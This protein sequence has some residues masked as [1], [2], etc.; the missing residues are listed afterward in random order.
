MKTSLTL[1]MP[2]YNEADS[3]PHV[4]PALL[5]HCRRRGWKLIVVDDG[6]TD[7]TQ[8]ALRQNMDPAVM[9]IFR[10]KVNRGYGG[11]LKTGI[12][13]AQTELVATI[14]AD[15]QHHA[16]DI[17]AML[18]AMRR[19]D[20]D[21]VVGRRVGKGAW[22]L[23][24]RTGRWVIR[25]LTRVLLPHHIHDINS[26]LK[27]SPYPDGPT[28]HSR[29]ARTGWRSVTPSMLVFR[30]PAPS[31]NRAPDSRA[32]SSIREELDHVCSRRLRPLCNCCTSWF[33]SIP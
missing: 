15:G 2:A 7:G 6:S 8:E 28:L 3:L 24:R 19:Q 1:V 17:E 11:A 4:L 32:A 23:Y 18:E 26:G 10:H 9:Q 21:M 27:L 5:E 16:D 13:N 20:A 30:E 22:S 12:R 14:D 29:V 31:R 25:T 33:C